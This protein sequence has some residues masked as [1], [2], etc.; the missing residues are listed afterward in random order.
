MLHGVGGFALS[1]LTRIGDE[2]AAAVIKHNLFAIAKKNWNLANM[3]VPFILDDIG[4][5]RDRP[6]I[7]G[8]LLELAQE[9]PSAEMQERIL[10]TLVADRALATIPDMP[11]FAFPSYRDLSVPTRANLLGL[12]NAVDT[13]A[14]SPKSVELINQLKALLSPAAER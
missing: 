3:D 13:K 5:G 10:K 9:A 12:V 11:T 8:L 4:R 14:L 7:L 6:A 1:S 2:R